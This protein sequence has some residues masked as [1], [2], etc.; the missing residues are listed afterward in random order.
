ME[1]KKETKKTK[2]NPINPGLII[3]ILIIAGLG[4][5][6]FKQGQLP[7]TNP[8]QINQTQPSSKQT[9]QNKT[10]VI[11]SIKDAIIKNVSFKCQYQPEGGNQIITMYFKGGKIRSEYSSGSKT[12]NIAIV[13]NN[14]VWN[15]QPKEKKGVVFSI[16][17]FKGKTTPDNQSYDKETIIKQAEKYRQNCRV[18]NL[19]DSLFVPPADIKFQDMDEMMKGMMQK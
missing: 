6:Y 4:F 7:K 12:E 5:L 14:R 13:D 19:S 10:G 11:E 3:L 9:N 16:D 1:E 17:L 15:W 2:Q 8:N 18:E